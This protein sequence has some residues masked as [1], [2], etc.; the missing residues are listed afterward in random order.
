MASLRKKNRALHWIQRRRVKGKLNDV[1]PCNA[2]T[3][4]NM[5]YL[6]AYCC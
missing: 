5:I 6:R 3:E 1:D 2:T 4:A